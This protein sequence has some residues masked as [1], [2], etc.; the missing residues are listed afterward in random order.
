MV[1]YYCNVYTSDF[2]Y[3]DLKVI[4]AQLVL[5]D[6]MVYQVKMVSMEKREKMVILVM[7]VHVVIKDNVLLITLDLLDLKAKREKKDQRYTHNKSC[8]KVPMF[9]M[10]VINFIGSKG[11]HRISWSQRLQRREGAEILTIFTRS[12]LM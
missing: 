8:V 7:K 11:Y 12:L 6:M 2:A 9:T 4:L 5:V 10:L 3:R 1:S